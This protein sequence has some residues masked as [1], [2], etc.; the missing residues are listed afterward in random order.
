MVRPEQ[1]GR[2]AIEVMLV[3]AV[4]QAIKASQVQ[5]GLRAIKAI[6]VSRD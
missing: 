1:W 6:K 4:W 3:L 2:K 5:P